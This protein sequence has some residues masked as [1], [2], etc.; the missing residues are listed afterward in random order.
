[1][2]K[3]KYLI[4]NVSGGF[5]K[6]IVATAVVRQLAEKFPDRKIIITSPHKNAWLNN[7]RIEKVVD[8]EKTPNFFAEVKK[9]PNCISFIQDPYQ[10]EDFTYRRKHLI[11]IWCELCG[12]KWDKKMPEIFFTEAERKETLAV[13]PKGKPIFVIQTNGGYI[14]QAFP[15]SWARD[16]PLSIAREI[17]ETMKEKGYEVIHIRRDNQWSLDGTIWLPVG[18]REFLCAMEFSE[19]RLLIDSAPQ[20]VAA[21]LNL[22]S[23][24][25]WIANSPTVL[26]YPMH[27]NILPNIKE[28]FRHL[29]DAYLDKYNIWGTLQECPYDTDRIFD[30]KEI[31][32]KL[33]E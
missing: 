21:A 10:T 13:L 1:M 25:C 23:V 14:N 20:H 7:P 24:I 32:Q 15:I 30:V 11:E 2:R 4:F 6:N 3:D 16:L 28:E 12:L 19:K 31:L 5:G 29:P 8:L 17:V 27:R 9:D 33:N 22:P 18:F 26:S